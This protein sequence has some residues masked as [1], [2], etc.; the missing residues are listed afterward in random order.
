MCE[1]TISLLYK[2]L[3]P[4]V[5]HS[6]VAGLGIHSLSSLVSMHTDF[7]IPL[8]LRPSSQRYSNSVLS[9]FTITISPLLGAC[10]ASHTAV[11]ATGVLFIK[12]L[13]YNYAHLC[14][15]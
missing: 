7:I 11:R 10:G 13:I 8:G 14:R 4:G 3:I 5:W 12:E 9:T 2:Q 15:G 6:N 1:E